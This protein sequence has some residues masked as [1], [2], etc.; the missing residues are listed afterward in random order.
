MTLKELTL[1]PRDRALYGKL[2]VSFYDI[3]IAQRCVAFL[4]KKSWHGP[5]FRRCGSAQIQLISHTTTMIISY[6]RPF[7]PGRASNV[8]FSERL[9]RQY[10]A[11]HRRL[12]A[13]LLTLRDETE[14]H[15]DQK[16]YMI[17]PF[18]SIHFKSI[19]QLPYTY[20]SAEEI[21]R[22]L[23]MT[24]GLMGRISVRMEEIHAAARTSHGS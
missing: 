6:S 14:A 4:K 21:D 1:S 13:K 15:M 2:Y 23:E 8:A 12:H 9:L 20:F 18:D 16:S 19:N 3:G 5:T 10:T 22:F 11:D 24:A 7:K 17:R